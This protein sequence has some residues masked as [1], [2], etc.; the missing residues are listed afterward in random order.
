[1]LDN[2]ITSLLLSRR[3]E[4]DTNPPMFAIF[5]AAWMIFPATASPN[6]ACS[7]R[8][9]GLITASA[10]IS[11]KPASRSFSAVAGPTPGRSSILTSGS[12]SS[13]IATTSTSGTSSSFCLVVF[14]FPAMIPSNVLP[15]IKKRRSLP[16]FMKVVKA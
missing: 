4:P 5:F 14:D 15:Y 3:A 12:N 6:S 13:S 8:S 7:A 10:S 1:M 2:F 16:G 9:G 11:S